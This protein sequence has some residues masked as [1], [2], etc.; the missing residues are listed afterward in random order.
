MLLWFA[1]ACTPSE[2]EPS[3]PG[4]EAGD[5]G[6]SANT[7][8]A[9]TTSGSTAHTGTEPVELPLV[10]EALDCALPE[11]SDPP[12]PTVGDLHQVVLPDVV[13]NDGSP[14]VAYLRAALDPAHA[15]DF[16]LQLD[17]GAFCD[18]AEGCAAR[19]CG[20]GNYDA[21]DM[22]SAWRKSRAS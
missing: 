20:E 9:S 16:V 5:T 3:G 21:R 22:S 13:C 15:R 18:S 6:A 2:S 4:L 19:W 1:L 10:S 11:P 8:T 14:A 7:S 17:G 12:E